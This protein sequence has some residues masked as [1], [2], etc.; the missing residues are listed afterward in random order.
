MRAWS[1]DG[2]LYR[3]HLAPRSGVLNRHSMDDGGAC[4]LIRLI[5]VLSTRHDTKVL[6]CSVIVGCQVPSKTPAAWHASL[7]PSYIVRELAP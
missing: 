2:T 7:V 5:A 1:F 6:H 3:Q 4:C